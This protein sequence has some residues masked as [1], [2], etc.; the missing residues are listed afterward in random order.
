[1]TLTRGQF[2]ACLTAPLASQPAEELVD[3]A[4][5]G[6]D[7]RIDVQAS[8]PRVKVFDLRRLDT[9]LTPAGEFFTFHQTKTI[10]AI[11]VKNWHLDI[12]GCVARPRT[13]T[14][15]ELMQFPAKKLAATIECSGNNG[16]PRLMNGLV[17]NGEWTGVELAPL[18]RECGV[19]PEAREVVFFGS[20]VERERK[21]PIEDREL[22]VP[23]ARS[24]FVQDALDGTA[25]LA[26]QLN[27]RALSPEQG[28]PLRLILP[29]WYGMTQIKWINRIVVLDRRYEGRHMARN[30]HSIDTSG[31]VA[32]ETSI[33]RMRLKSVV[34]RVTRRQSDGRPAHTI[35][36]AAWGGRSPVERVQVRIDD[37][38][39]REAAIIEKGAPYAWSLWQA[40]WTGASAG[41]HRIVSRAVDSRG[42][43]QPV[44][45]ELL[46]ARE[47]NSQ[48]T[49][50]IILPR[51]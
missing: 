38:P 32:L 35:T 15:A 21:W 8:G 50:K 11:D 2:L 47:N 17:S 22:E 3:F 5:Y 33:A 44:R 45:S 25:L 19:L 14:F 46:S 29:G 24:I 18:L 30:Y 27:G 41:E 34:A 20:D 40:P 51:L 1:M 31:K 28:F 10:D 43:T 4:D 39:W 42:E 48:W 13:V 9:W 37:Q 16:H 49:R 12:S 23:H 7:F 6:P 26:L 36:G